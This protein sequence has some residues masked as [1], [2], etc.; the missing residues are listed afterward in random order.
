MEH[1]T[2]IHIQ[3]FPRVSFISMYKAIFL[4]RSEQNVAKML[5]LF[6]PCLYVRL[7]ECNNSRTSKRIFTKINTGNFY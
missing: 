7:Y 3:I 5:L 2:N 4:A 1:S 6:P